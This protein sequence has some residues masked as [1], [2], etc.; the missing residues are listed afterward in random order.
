MADDS[1]VEDKP[2]EP[3]QRKLEEARRKGDIAKSM[4]IN[5]SMAYLGLFLAVAL[6]S[7]WVVQ[8]IGEALFFFLD[9]PQSAVAATLGQGSSVMSFQFLGTVFWSTAPIF[10]LPA[11]LVIV[12]LTIQGAWVFSGDKVAPKLSRIS[13]IENIK[14]K[15]GANGIFEFFKS[16]VKLIIY[17]FLIGYFL[18]L[19]AEEILASAAVDGRIVPMVLAELAGQ[20]LVVCIVISASLAA[21]DYMWQLAELRRRNMMSRKELQDEAKSTEGDPHLKQERRQRAYKIAMSGMMAEVPK[22]DV[23][24]T[25]PTHYAVALK[26]D[27]TA[28]SAPECVAKGKDKLAQKIRETAIEA[29]VPIHPDPPTARALFS[30]LELGDQI[31]PEHYMAVAAAIRFADK[32]KRRSRWRA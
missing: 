1:D 11:V 16:S 8:N 15:Y 28:G 18:F 24:I 2:F 7:G 23:V 10:V 13:P 12:G 22:S 26:W 3:T 9:E 31:R 17:C 14:N 30:S 6:F 29:G 27:R 5:V 4:E 25:N 19:N 21:I 20:F 32:M